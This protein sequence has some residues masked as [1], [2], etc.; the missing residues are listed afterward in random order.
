MNETD[1]ILK[2]MEWLLII[3]IVGCSVIIVIDIA[4][5]LGLIS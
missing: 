3:I 1:I 2:W 5:L 4:Q